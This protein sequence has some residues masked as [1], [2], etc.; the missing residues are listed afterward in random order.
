MAAIW[1]W[2]GAAAPADHVGAGLP[3]R[4]RIFAEIFRLGR[5]H[6]APAHLF[7]PAGVGHDR[8]MAIR[9]GLAHLFEDAQQLV[10][11]AR[12]VDPDQVRPELRGC[13]VATLAGSSPSRVRSSRVKVIEASTGSSGA[14][15]RAAWMA[16]LTSN[17]SVMVS[18]ISRSTPALARAAICSP[19]ACARLFRLDPAKR[20]Q[21][22]PQRADVA[23]DQ[24]G[25]EGGQDDP[26]APARPRRR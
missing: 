25:F 1:S 5:V 7:G 3:E 22:H 23:G 2:G 20:G 19:K 16:S 24:T 8:E 21:A 15:S 18:M 9:H 10:R 13:C 14:T 12:A 11:P 17:R 26:P 4:Q 6:D